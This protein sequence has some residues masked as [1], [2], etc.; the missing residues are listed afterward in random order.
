[1]I[2]QHATRAQAFLPG[3]V[4]ALQR[5]ALSPAARIG[6]A[7]ALA[8]AA[9]W[10][11]HATGDAPAGAPAAAGELPLGPSQMLE[12]GTLFWAVLAI[13]Q[14]ACPPAVHAAVACWSCG[15]GLVLAVALE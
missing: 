6:A 12:V 9:V 5:V 1:M 11:L 3:P 8:L 15:A 14:H 13:A 2:W 10:T 4:R 7:A